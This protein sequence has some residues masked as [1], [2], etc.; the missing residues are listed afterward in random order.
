MSILFPIRYPGVKRARSI[1]RLQ[2]VV[3]MLVVFLRSV[4]GF[5]FCLIFPS[6]VVRFSQ[7]IRQMLCRGCSLTVHLISIIVNDLRISV[8]LDVAVFVF[9]FFFCTTTPSFLYTDQCPMP[10]HPFNPKL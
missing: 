7:C 9:I 8:V 4:H 2:I 6:F 3:Y 10:T 5:I 1:F